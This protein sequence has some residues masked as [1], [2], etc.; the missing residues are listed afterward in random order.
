MIHQKLLDAYNTKKI[1]TIDKKVVEFHS[2][3]NEPEA[4]MI[5]RAITDIKAKNTLEVGLA[6]GASAIT[7]CDSARRINQSSMHYAIDPYQFKDYGGV[8]V[9][10]INEAGFSDNFKL[11]EGKTHEV[12][13]Y[14]FENKVELDMA[15]IDGWHTFD[16]TF[17]DFFLIDKVLK[18]GG[19]LAFHD[20]YGLSK[21]KVL[22]FI[23][24]HRDYEILYKYQIHAES[25]YKTLKMFAWRI[26][27]E[28]RLLFSWFHWKFQTK[29]PYGIIFLR[30]KSSFEPHFDFY[31]PF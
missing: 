21:Q 16:Y 22:N 28:P 23:K 19:L 15:F 25:R 26:I 12:F 17:A 27:K 10:L 29:S 13:H 24:T 30:K 18:V 9:N 5:S 7:F 11:L 6:M 8:G 20:M 1:S 4:E 3:I 31:K 14:F 2:G